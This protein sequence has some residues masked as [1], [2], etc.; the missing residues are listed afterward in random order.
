M[1]AAGSAQ[2]TSRR[3]GAEVPIE[4]GRGGLEVAMVPGGG[5]REER[6]EVAG[7]GRHER[8]LLVLSLPR[9][10]GGLPPFPFPFSF[11]HI[12]FRFLLFKR[13]SVSKTLRHLEHLEL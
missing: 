10:A 13:L 5:A 1:A 4:G 12:K 8:R 3:R 9:E 6:G 2:E 11:F 7:D